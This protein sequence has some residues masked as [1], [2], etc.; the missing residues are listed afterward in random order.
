MRSTP[1][2]SQETPVIYSNRAPDK[3]L[4]GGAVRVIIGGRPSHWIAPGDGEEDE[5]FT[6]SVFSHSE[7]TYPDGKK[8]TTHTF[9][10]PQDLQEGHYAVF[11]NGLLWPLHHSMTPWKGLDEEARNEA[12]PSDQRFQSSLSK[13][14]YETAWEDYKSFNA[15]ASE[16]MQQWS[17]DSQNS[18]PIWVHDYQCVGVKGD[19]LS[20]HIPFPTLAY[21]DKLHVEDTPILQTK[22]FQEY[23]EGITNYKLVS[24]QRAGDMKNF[25]ETLGAL[26]KDFYKNNEQSG[27]ST[28][29]QHVRNFDINEGAFVTAFGHKF[30]VMNFPVGITRSAVQE[31]AD[32]YKEGDTLLSPSSLS[33]THQT[34]AKYEEVGWDQ[35][36]V[37][38]V[39][40]S[41]K[42]NPDSF[43][44][45]EALG[46]ALKTDGQHRIFVALSRNDYTKNTLEKL[47]AAE[48][49]LTTHPE[50]IGHTHFAFFLETTRDG[51]E[52]Y[53]KYEHDVFEAAKRL[54]QNYGNS[55]AVFPTGGQYNALMHLLQHPNTVCL[56]A[57]SGKD[58]FELT[59]SEAVHVNATEKGH[60]VAVIVTDGIGSHD[61]LSGTPE[62]PGAFVVKSDQPRRGI[63]SDLA[64]TYA[65]I[66]DMAKHNPQEIASRF[67]VM[68]KSLQTYTSQGFNNAVLDHYR[69]AERTLR[70]DASRQIG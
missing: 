40:Q 27:I 39:R 22:P 53:D 9:S 61:V 46:D 26:D 43:T 66:V 19:I 2:A 44:L 23:L 70:R 50:E 28:D 1:P 47:L 54:N 12:G 7:I 4:T 24:F 29:G 49:F 20:F 31:A 51:V 21:L 67:D 34:A 13:R 57:A 17:A 59:G 42:T 52:G 36:I 58:G 8:L 45:E 37:E 32:S 41:S 25:L 65:Q 11:S 18:A 33:K 3:Q 69:Q 38:R 16:A 5:Q 62:H 48:E 63:V 35:S 60:P 15:I 56:N 14:Q 68:E 64:D 6:G 30:R 10:F 55:V